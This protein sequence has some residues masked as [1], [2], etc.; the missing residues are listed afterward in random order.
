MNLQ[1]RFLNLHSEAGKLVWIDKII[2][3]VL[4][5][6]AYIGGYKGQTTYDGL[7]AV[8]RR[9]A[10]K[11][12]Y[13]KLVTRNGA[14]SA[15]R[16]YN[17]TPHGFK[18]VLAAAEKTDAG[19]RDVALITK[20]DVSTR[21]VHSEVSGRLDPHLAKAGYVPAT[22]ATTAKIAGVE[23]NDQGFYTRTIGG[24][25]VVKRILGTPKFQRRTALA[26]SA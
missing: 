17:D 25:E 20:G 14:V 5:S 26:S 22:R 24:R 13:W 12:G 8:L 6:Y 4:A 11:P 19:R 23:P 16:F 2:P 15:V 10:L 3:V 1:E 18:A 21:D 9:E 7:K